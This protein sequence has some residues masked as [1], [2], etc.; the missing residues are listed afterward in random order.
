MLKGHTE[1]NIQGTYGET[2]YKGHTE[3]KHT[4]D[5][6]K[7]DIKGTYGGRTYKGHAEEKH[8]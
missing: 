4:R 5:I 6:R 3:D 2:R 8:M 1:E 7:K